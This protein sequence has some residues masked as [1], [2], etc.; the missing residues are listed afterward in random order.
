MACQP[1][2]KFDFFRQL[3]LSNPRPRGRRMRNNNRVLT[4]K[5]PRI[6][7]FSGVGDVLVVG[8]NESIFDGC[9]EIEMNVV[10]GVCFRGRKNVVEN[11]SMRIAR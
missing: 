7:A 5:Q 4:R 2:K 9:I 11:I 3:K 6:S 1:K 10:Y 8:P